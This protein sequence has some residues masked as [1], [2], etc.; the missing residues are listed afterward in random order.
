[1]KI[2]IAIERNESLKNCFVF[3][4]GMRNIDK[5]TDAK[6][7]SKNEM[8]KASDAD[9]ESDFKLVGDLFNYQTVQ[10]EAKNSC[11][12]IITFS[13]F[14]A[15]TYLRCAL[16]FQNSSNVKNKK[17]LSPVQVKSFSNITCCSV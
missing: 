5:K 15:A 17:H 14:S 10:S 3:Y 2:N 11:R 6:Q 9:C 1:M 13:Q 7:Y 12:K 16:D 8:I 4:I